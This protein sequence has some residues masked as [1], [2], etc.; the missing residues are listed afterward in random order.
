MALLG[1]LVFVLLMRGPIHVGKAVLDV[2]TMLVG[3]L[4][5][6][7]GYQAI[8]MGYAARIY[9]VL[10]G[11]ARPSRALELGFRVINLERGLL[12]GGVMAACGFA[13]IVAMTLIWADGS[14]GPL[15][16]ARTLRPLLAGITLVT[17]G[18][19]T[20]LMSFFYSMLG[21]CGRR[22]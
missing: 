11:I 2:H 20:V 21:L 19:Q 4:L 10:E 5:V 1:G 18:V 22:G 7:M 3:A 6:T 13:I 15:D 14:F 17:L 8:T 16:T 12:A 9:A